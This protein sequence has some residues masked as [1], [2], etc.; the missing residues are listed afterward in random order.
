MKKFVEFLC[1]FSV[2]LAFAVP[3]FAQDK[4]KDTKVSPDESAVE[5]T[6]NQNDLSKS[7]Y[8]L[9]RGN[10]DVQ[11]EYG[12]SPFNPSNFAGPKEFDV[13]GR[14]LH[15]FSFRFGRIVGTKRNVSYQYM[16]GVTP[17]TVFTKNEVVNTDYI[18]PTATPDIAPTKRETTYSTG[19]QPINFKFIFLA[20]NRLKPYAQTGA[21]ILVVSKAVPRSAQH[22][23]S[24]FGR[25]WRRLDVYALA[26]K[27]GQ[28]RL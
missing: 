24:I 7:E 17:L 20:K 8:S 5:E 4:I 28:L 12:I 3:I 15:L 22:A 13:Y 14:H 16:F 2:F 19:F 18:S 11:I 25:F 1:R 23:F 6:V 10:K 21:G 27:S 9:K 26:E